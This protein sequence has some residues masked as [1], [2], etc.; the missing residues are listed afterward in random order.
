[1]F[2]FFALVSYPQNNHRDWDWFLNH[3]T[4][5]MHQALANEAYRILHNKDDVD[6]VLQEA[7]VIGI[8]KCE[9]LRDETKL[10]QWMFKIVRREAYAHQSK[11]SIIKLMERIKDIFEPQ[12]LRPDAYLISEEENAVL[13][14][15]LDTLDEQT[16]KIVLVK[17]SE[18]IS[19]KEVAYRFDLNYN[20]VRS[21]YQRAMDTI[22]HRMEAEY[23]EEI[24]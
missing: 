3:I 18:G 23:D 17:T 8:T 10:F 15:V 7:M 24:N 22:R 12:P 13:H 16:R 9:Q 4:P 11:A 2:C 1:M 19:L 5:Q 20:T 14:K 21:K 6:D